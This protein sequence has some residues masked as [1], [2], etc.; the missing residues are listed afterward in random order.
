MIYYR[1][2]ESFAFSLHAE[3]KN[4]TAKTSVFANTSFDTR[5]LLYEMSRSAA[6][7]TSD[8]MMS[9]SNFSSCVP[10]DFLSSPLDMCRNFRVEVI[11]DEIT[12]MNESS[13]PFDSPQDF[14]S[15]H[16]PRLE[17]EGI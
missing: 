1:G 2:T 17:P 14:P 16:E 9:R 11:E 3:A 10:E 4:V 13:L 12:Y 5:R 7:V 8:V 6:K 15:K